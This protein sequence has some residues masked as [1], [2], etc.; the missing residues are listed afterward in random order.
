MQ[1]LARKAKSRGFELLWR[2]ITAAFSLV[3]L[4][5]V[6]VVLGHVPIVGSLFR[7]LQQTLVLGQVS[8]SCTAHMYCVFLLQ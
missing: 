3:C 4:Y 5:P 8:G 2:P 7:F 6:G 1:L